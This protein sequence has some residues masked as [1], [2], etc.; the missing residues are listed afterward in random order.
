MKGM[1]KCVEMW[2]GDKRKCGKMCWSR[3]SGEVGLGCGERCEK[4]VGVEGRSG[5]SMR[6]CLAVCLRCGKVCLS[7]GRSEGKCVGVGGM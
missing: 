5:G 7:V 1:G 6:R 2:K 4:C 3:R